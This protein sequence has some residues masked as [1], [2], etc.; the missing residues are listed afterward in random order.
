LR[1]IVIKTT[2]KDGKPY[3]HRASSDPYHKVPRAACF[4]DLKCAKAILAFITN[5]FAQ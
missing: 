3:K 2:K 5:Q 1:F 4:T